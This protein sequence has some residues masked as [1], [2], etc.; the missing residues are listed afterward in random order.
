MQTLADHQSLLL[1]ALSHMLAMVQ[2]IAGQTIRSVSSLEAFQETFSGRLMALAGVHSLL[3]ESSWRGAALQ[4]VVAEAL[5]PF[6]LADRISLIGPDVGLTAKSALVFSLILHELV[7]NATKYGAL[8][9]PDGRVKLVWQIVGV[10]T[11]RVLRLRWRETGGPEV[12]PPGQPGFG[13]T[14]IERSVAYDLDGKVKFDF[15]PHGL[16]CVLLLPYRQD[17][18]QDVSEGGNAAA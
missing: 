10:G 8:S 14:L 11:E 1:A 4:T 5:K 15:E 16:R 9:T 13:L 2:A 17:N 18:F 6:E 3:T 7:T 12:A